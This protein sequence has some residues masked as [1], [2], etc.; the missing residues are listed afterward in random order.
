MRG[1]FLFLL[2]FALKMS[3]ISVGFVFVLLEGS[4][5]PNVRLNCPY[6]ESLQIP[7]LQSSVLAI[8]A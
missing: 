8:L 2:D 6:K 4:Y 3:S 5:M 1:F 7:L